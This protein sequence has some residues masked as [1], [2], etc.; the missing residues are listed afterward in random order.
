[1]N[2]DLKAARAALDKK[3][4]AR[5]FA[6]Q[7]VKAEKAALKTAVETLAHATEAREI[8]Q[9]V[10]AAVQRRVHDRLAGLVNDCLKAV[11]PD[12]E[13]FKVLFSPTKRGKTEARLAWFRGEYEVPVEDVGF[14]VRDVAAFALRVAAVLVRPKRRRL[15]VLD[16]SFRHIHNESVA[17]RVKALLETV[18]DKLKIQIIQVTHNRAIACGTVIDL[19]GTNTGDPRPRT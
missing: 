11:F 4:A 5:R 6:V 13:E 19:G 7:T 18:A 17:E 1:M 10:A 14:G 12:P 3:L 16:E 9:T 8:L 2:L 15:V